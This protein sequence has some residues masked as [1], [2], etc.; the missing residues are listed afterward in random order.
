MTNEIFYTLI[1]EIIDL[2]TSEFE[3]C[4][5]KATEIDDQFK[6]EFFDEDDEVTDTF[7]VR[8]IGKFMN[9]DMVEIKMPNRDDETN[10]ETYLVNADV[11]TMHV[12]FVACVG[13]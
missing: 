1:G 2:L 3:D 12:I 11:W 13:Y 4:R 8:D 7:F 9:Q 5:V 6:I 10:I